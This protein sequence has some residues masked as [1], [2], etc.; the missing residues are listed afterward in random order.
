MISRFVLSL[1]GEKSADSQSLGDEGGLDEDGD[2]VVPRRAGSH[3]TKLLLIG[4][5]SPLFGI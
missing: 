1:H 2:L 4:N 3:R 5:W